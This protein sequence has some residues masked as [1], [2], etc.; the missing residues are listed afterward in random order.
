VDLTMSRMWASPSTL[1]L[2]IA[3][4][5]KDAS[6]VQFCELHI[7]LSELGETI[8]SSILISLDEDGRYQHDEPLF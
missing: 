4:T 5:P 7:P 1:H 2:K 6:W 8:R 3:I